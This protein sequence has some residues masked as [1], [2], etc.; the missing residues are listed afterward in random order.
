M[1][2]INENIFHQYNK[3]KQGYTRKENSFKQRVQKFL[4]NRE[5]AD[6]YSISKDGKHL[7]ANDDVYIHDEDIHDGKLIVQFGEVKGCFDCICC[8]SLTSLEGAPK[9]VGGDFSCYSCKKLTSLEG[10]PE[11]VGKYFSCSECKK[12]TSLEGAPKE[13]HRSFECANCDSLT[14]LEG[15]PKK[16][17]RNFDCNNCKN[18][19]SLVGLPEKVG[20][21]FDCSGCENLTSIEGLPKEIGGDLYI[22]KRFKGKIPNDVIIKGEIRYVPNK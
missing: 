5:D 19:T 17:G 1:E 9:E 7:N 4:S 20:G 3:W 13:V 8:A 10:A 21:Y 12:L 22:D 11:K 16:I 14:S 15:A 2:K 6:M 18:L